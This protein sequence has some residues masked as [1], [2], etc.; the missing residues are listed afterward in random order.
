MSPIVTAYLWLSDVIWLTFL[1]V[2]FRDERS[3]SK[4]IVAA[5][6]VMV[7]LPLFA[8]WGAK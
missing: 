3:P 8:L 5:R 7:A 6:V 1:I 4:L 2:G